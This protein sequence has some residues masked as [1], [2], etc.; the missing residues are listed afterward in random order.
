MLSCETFEKKVKS[1]HFIDYKT[2][3]KQLPQAFVTS[4]KL[5]FLLIYKFIFFKTHTKLLF[6]RGKKYVLFEK[7]LYFMNFLFQKCLV[8]YYNFHVQKYT[9]CK[10]TFL[11]NFFITFINI[12]KKKKVKGNKKSNEIFKYV[13]MKEQKKLYNKK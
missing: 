2:I 7:F 11:F 10:F 1:K 6:L 13:T 4:T 9:V 3:L 12:K 8:L 5:M